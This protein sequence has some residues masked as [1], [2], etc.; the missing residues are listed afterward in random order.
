VGKIHGNGLS[1]L[2]DLAFSNRPLR[3]AEEIGRRVCLSTED[4]T[5]WNM[6]KWEHLIPCEKTVVRSYAGA[7]RGGEGMAL[8]I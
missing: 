8:K 1:D 5:G 2:E 7:E 6:Y 4:L 3:D